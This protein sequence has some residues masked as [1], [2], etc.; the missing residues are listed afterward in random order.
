MQPWQ[1]QPASPA[2]G[3][4]QPQQ[5]YP[6]SPPGGFAGPQQAQQGQ[7]W[8][9]PQGDSAPPW[10]GGD[11]PPLT[12]Q[13]NADW[14]VSQGPESFDDE[15]SP[16]GKGRTIAFS[17]LAVVLLVGIGVAVW[18]LF[19]ADDSS[20]D[21]R[22]QDAGPHNGQGSQQVST[23]TSTPLP[24][25]PAAKQPP[26]D[27]ESALIDPPGEE[28]GGGG[29]F[30]S[31]TIEDK[32]IL[33]DSVVAA[34]LDT[35]MGKGLLKTT[36]T[37]ND[38][39]VSLYSIEVGSES[40][41]TTVADEYE[42]TQQDGNIPPIRD[43]SLQGVPVF[44]AGNANDN[45]V[46]RSVYVLYDRVVILEVFGPEREKVESLFADML[47]QQVEHAPPSYTGY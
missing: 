41:A 2:G 4:Q 29:E 3:F 34:L 17:T 47:D 11:F 13:S 35:D 42:V 7:P 31:E 38:T 23:P 8:N 40:E 20:P 27:N 26:T 15:P 36:V 12:P 33:P 16:S 9:A 28:R 32:G 44:G 22:A 37:E 30:D 39:T 18:L 1:S 25:P 46:Y 21:N 5:G 6:A 19:L 45:S 24:T 14:G 10:G 43:L